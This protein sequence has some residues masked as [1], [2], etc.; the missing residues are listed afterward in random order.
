MTSYA[1]EF[2]FEG[3]TLTTKFGRDLSCARKRLAENGYKWAT[4]V[5]I[6]AYEIDYLGVRSNVRA[7]A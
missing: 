7:V 2:K 6:I 4:D 3:R 1:I 5:R